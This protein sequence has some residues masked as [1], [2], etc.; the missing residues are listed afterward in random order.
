MQ[1]VIEHSTRQNNPQPVKTTHNHPK[2]AKITHNHSKPTT[3]TQNHPQSNGLKFFDISG[4]K[5]F[6][7]HYLILQFLENNLRNW[8]RYF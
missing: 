7:S 1:L 5:I 8:L 3:T 2:P 6:A 4:R